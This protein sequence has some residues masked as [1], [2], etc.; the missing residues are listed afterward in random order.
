MTPKSVLSRPEWRDPGEAASPCPRGLPALDSESVGWK[1]SSPTPRASH[2]Y[3]WKGPTRLEAAG[4]V[5]FFSSP[6]ALVSQSFVFP[7]YIKLGEGGGLGV[8]HRQ[9]PCRRDCMC[10]FLLLK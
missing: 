3:S 7:F 2:M 1:C 8:Q 10:D 9:H 4:H 5:C 6:L